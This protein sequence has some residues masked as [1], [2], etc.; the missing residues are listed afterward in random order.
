M[1]VRR[2]LE[3]VVRPEEKLCLVEVIR[4][5]NDRQSTVAFG[6]LL[7]KYCKLEEIDYDMNLDFT[8]EF[9]LI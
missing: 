9:L 6:H 2:V 7:K 8:C 1:T 5:L 4:F 3:K